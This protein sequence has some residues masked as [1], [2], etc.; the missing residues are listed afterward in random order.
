M[1]LQPSSATAHLELAAAQRLLGDTGAAIDGCH[2]ALARQ[3]DLLQAW[4]SLGHI[5]M[6]KGEMANARHCFQ[7]VLLRRSDHLQ[8]PEATPLLPLT[9]HSLPPA[10]RTAAVLVPIEEWRRVQESA[11]PSFKELLMAH[12]PLLTCRTAMDLLDTNIVSELMQ[13]LPLPRILFARQIPASLR[14]KFQL[15]EQPLLSLELT[16][17]VA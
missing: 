6:S 14:Q 7:Q 1:E 8:E 17:A 11:R 10:L 16:A 9:I 4:Y 3:P 15:H 5:W 2:A 12:E 13:E